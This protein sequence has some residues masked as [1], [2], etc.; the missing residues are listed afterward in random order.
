MLKEQAL[1]NIVNKEL[2]EKRN[3]FIYCEFTGDREEAISYR[4]KQI[5]EQECTLRESEVTVLESANPS[6]LKRE[7]WMHQKASQ[8]TK[9]F[10]TN[11][12][13]VSTGLDFAFR[14]HG[15]D[16]NYPTIIFIKLDMT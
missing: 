14:Y 1:V 7:E 16:Y 8:G 9:V 15:K 11:A 10:I 13:C 3:C 12:K 2:E 5:L 4:L 6:A